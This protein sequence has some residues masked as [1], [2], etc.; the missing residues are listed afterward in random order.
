MCVSGARDRIPMCRLTHTTDA[1]LA[2]HAVTHGRNVDAGPGDGKRHRLPAGTTRSYNQPS[3]S[4]SL[5]MRSSTLITLLI[6]IAAVVSAQGT[7]ADYKRSEELNRKYQGLAVDV[8][9][10]PHW[11][12]NTSFWYRKAVPGGN[13]FVVVDATT[14]EKQPALDHAKVA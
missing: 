13:A 6:P 12:G 5:L 7:A 14:K 10:T 4:S 1:G 2:E 11:I 9:E 8:P 3:R